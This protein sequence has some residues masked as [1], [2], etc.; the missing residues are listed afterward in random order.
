VGGREPAEKHVFVEVIVKRRGGQRRGDAKQAVSIEEEVSVDSSAD[1]RGNEGFEERTN[2]GQRFERSTSVLD[3]RNK[4]TISTE[5]SS[6]REERP[7]SRLFGALRT[8][9][10]LV[11]SGR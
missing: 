7:V 3:W 8:R 5:G 9:L 1:T 6:N 4:E 2:R 11:E 10:A